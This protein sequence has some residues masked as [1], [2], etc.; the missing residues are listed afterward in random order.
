M[1]TK[2]S[3]IQS[4]LGLSINAASAEAGQTS[5]GRMSGWNILRQHYF[6]GQSVSGGCLQA[7]IGADFD[8]CRVW[9]LSLITQQAKALKSVED[10]SI[11][12]GLLVSQDF[13]FSTILL[14]SL[15]DCTLLS[16]YCGRCRA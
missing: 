7:S 10:L 5:K 15:L 16:L 4:F 11:D 9:S 8:V 12:A 3:I 14:A 2:L 6:R 13:L 1:K